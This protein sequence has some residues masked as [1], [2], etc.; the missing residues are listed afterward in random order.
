MGSDHAKPRTNY[1]VLGV[2]RS[3]STEVIRAAYLERARVLHPDVAESSGHIT[4]EHEMRLVNEAWRVLGVT[5]ARAEYDREL[6][7]TDPAPVGPT[8]PDDRTP[9]DEPEK[10]VP[11]LT[12]D[13]LLVATLVRGWPI[14]LLVL[15]AA[16][17]V[18]SAYATGDSE[19]PDPE[20]TDDIEVAWEPGDCLERLPEPTQVRCGDPHDA[21]VAAVVADDEG[22]P[23]TVGW[24]EADIAGPARLCIV[25]DR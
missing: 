22:C 3:A 13:S 5:E 11:I 18:F 25:Y 2:S 1:E 16:I 4:D 24:F 14:L 7:R 12:T 6:R 10:D 8:G 23:D 20:P 21:R 17:F 15:M 19:R 9:D